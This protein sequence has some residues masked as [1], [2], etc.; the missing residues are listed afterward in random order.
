M[1]RALPLLLALHAALGVPAAAAADTHADAVALARAGQHDAALAAL[2]RLAAQRPDDRQIAYDTIVVLGWAERHGQALAAA[3]RL[4]LAGAPPYVL[5]AVARAARHQKRF[6]L[7][8]STYLRSLALEPTRTDSRIGLALTHADAGE[9]AA[10]TKVLDPLA[11]V[12]APAPPVLEA[13][14]AIAAAQ[15]DWLTAL[16]AYQAAL[17]AAP[18]RTESLRGVVRSAAALGAP[19][20]AAAMASKHPGLVTDPELAAWAAD[21]TALG[22]RYGRTQERIGSGEARFEWLDRALARSDATAQRFAAEGAAAVRD[23]P[24]S[25]RLLQDRLVALSLRDRNAEAIALYRSMSDAGLALAPYASKAAADA[26]LDARRPAEALALYDAVLGV[27]PAD[28]DAAVGRFFALVESERLDAAAAYADALV[29]RTPAWLPPR[30]PNPDAV[31]AR[32]LAALA[33]LYGDRL[34]DAQGRVTTLRNDLPYNAGVREAYASTMQARG[35]PRLADAEFRRALAVDPDSAGLRAQRVE[36]LLAVNAFGEANEQL[37]DAVGLRADDP[38]VR[39]AMELWDVHSMRQLEVF[40]GY[41][42]ASGAPP[43]GD[44]DWRL[45]ARLYSQP[46]AEH[47][48]VFAQTA[49]AQADFVDGD[50]RWHREGLGVEYRARDLRGVAAVTTGSGDRTGLYA[51]GEWLPND[52]WSL[53]LAASSVSSNVPMQVWKAGVTASEVAALARWSASESRSIWGG[54]T[55]FDFSD[56]NDRLIGSLAWLE[57]WVSTPRWRLE[58][59]LA[60][61][62]SSN[63]TQGRPYFNPE[64]DQTASLTIAG[65]WL[66]WR[67]YERS[68]RQRLSVTAGGYRQDDFGTGRLLGIAYEHLWELDRRLFLRYALGRTLRPYDGV[69]SGRTYGSLS[70]DWRF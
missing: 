46:L 23:D 43:T 26:L 56:G 50:V 30:R 35:R 44:E 20:L 31:T 7:A 8:K 40:A 62:A 45:D 61:E 33:R 16:A 34:D 41:G 66:T 36:T 14:A 48:R 55:G 42:K 12:A 25:A 2:E 60:L 5:D 54:L 4:D 6:D 15:G 51:A 11:A 47:W 27:Q 58:T 22:I 32:T 1:R 65:E 57:R 13:R 24:L 63:S 9:F 21:E 64:D 3:E 69:Q 19:Q 49:R 70:L 28:F 67:Q 59:V 68:F 52:A 17:Q 10:A 18:G 38:R 53:G 39:R 37:V 29:E